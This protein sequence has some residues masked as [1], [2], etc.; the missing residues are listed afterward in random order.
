MTKQEFKDYMAKSLTEERDNI[1]KIKY[2]F[3]PQFWGDPPKELS[4][5]DIEKLIHQLECHGQS[6][7][8]GDTLVTLSETGFVEV[9]RLIRVINVKK[10]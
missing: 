3:Y 7:A 2:P 4:D 8:T 9:Y 5:K 6:I 1:K 10:Y